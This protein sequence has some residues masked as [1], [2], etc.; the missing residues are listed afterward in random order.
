[1]ENCEDDEKR[2]ELKLPQLYK[3]TFDAAD[4]RLYWDRAPQKAK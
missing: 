2:R 4:C 3:Q 1:M